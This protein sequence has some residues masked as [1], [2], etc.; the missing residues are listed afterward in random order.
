MKRDEAGEKEEEREEKNSSRVYE[1]E[2]KMRERRE[3]KLNG[4]L[5]H[6]THGC[7]NS[8]L[9]WVNFHIELQADHHQASNCVGVYINL[10]MWLTYKHLR[11]GARG[12]GRKKERKNTKKEHKMHAWWGREWREEE[13]ENKSKS[14]SK[15]KRST[16]HRRVGFSVDST[17][18]QGLHLNKCKVSKER[19]K[20]REE[21]GEWVSERESKLPCNWHKWNSQLRLYSTSL[22]VGNIYFYFLSFTSTLHSSCRL[23]LCIFHSLGFLLLTF[24]CSS[25]HTWQ[26]NSRLDLQVSECDLL[27]KSKRRER[28]WCET[29]RDETRRIKKDEATERKEAS[30]L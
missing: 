12:A 13:G 9:C 24:L 7:L 6:L 2:R 14:R 21:E 3:N 18:T 1:R 5:K 10:L 26:C 23:S 11:N 19:E 17:C 27:K 20:S 25:R 15:V 8:W 16:G 22:W 29:R 4:K 28:K 30:D